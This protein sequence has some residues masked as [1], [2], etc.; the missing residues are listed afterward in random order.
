MFPAAAERLSVEA[1]AQLAAIFAKRK[2][3]ELA[4]AEEQAPGD[5]RE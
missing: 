5:A 3:R 4:R 2:P 1:E